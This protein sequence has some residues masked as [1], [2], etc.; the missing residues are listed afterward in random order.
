[1]IPW[2]QCKQHKR[3]DTKQRLSG[4]IILCNCRWTI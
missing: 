1:M 2:Q 4:M 3:Q